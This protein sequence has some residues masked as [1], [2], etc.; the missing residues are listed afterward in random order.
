M[1]R[2]K[3]WEKRNVFS[4]DLKTATESLLRTGCPS[5]R[6]TNSVKSLKAQV[7]V[8]LLTQSFGPDP[9]PGWSQGLVPSA[10]RS[11]GPHPGPS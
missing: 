7:D 10:G 11:L 8:N 2:E 5:C 6:P 9:S 1:S 4:L 3:A